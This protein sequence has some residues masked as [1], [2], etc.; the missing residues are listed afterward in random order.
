MPSDAVRIRVRSGSNEIEIESNLAQIREALELV[1]EIISKF[2]EVPAARAPSAQQQQPSVPGAIQKDAGPTAMP[3]IMV[4]K[5]DSLGDIV[6]KFFNDPWGRNPRNL[7]EVREVLQLYGLTYPKQSV[8]VA[9]LRLAKSSKI[10]RF[11]GSGG[12]YVYTASTLAAPVQDLMR[13]EQAA[14]GPL[15]QAE[16]P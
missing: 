8:A 9:L 12:E 13:D 15:A 1:P 10:R 2:P 16:L 7:N 11:K 14:P 3:T 6:A 5:G 4:E